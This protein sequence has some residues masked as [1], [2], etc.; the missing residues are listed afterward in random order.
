MSTKKVDENVDKD[1]KVKKDKQN[2]DDDDDE[3][4]DSGF[5]CM[6]CDD[7]RVELDC[8]NNQQGELLPVWSSPHI[9]RSAS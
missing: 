7:F 3:L 1:G 6:G 8:I 9:F 5:Y 4:K 2:V